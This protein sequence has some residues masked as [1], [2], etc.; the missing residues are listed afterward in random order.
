VSL[1]GI[2]SPRSSPYPGATWERQEH[3]GIIREVL[4][5]APIEA[6]HMEKSQ[7][8]RP[9]L[10]GSQVLQNAGFI[11][12]LLADKEVAPKSAEAVESFETLADC[13]EM[14]RFEAIRDSLPNN[15]HPAICSIFGLL[16]RR[17]VNSRYWTE[18]DPCD[19]RHGSTDVSCQQ[20]V[21]ASEYALYE[22]F[23]NSEA[24]TT[25]QDFISSRPKLTRHSGSYRAEVSIVVPPVQYN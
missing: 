9:E 2:S 18:D 21:L 22:R 4:V 5:E 25:N 6:A 13:E 24:V 1:R 12:D 20:G 11:G 7:Q 15:V 14:E 8:E 3:G 19:A 23:C 16:P 10:R 17:P